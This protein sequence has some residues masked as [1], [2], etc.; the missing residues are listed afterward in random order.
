M[1]RCLF[2]LLCALWLLGTL[3]LPA[4]AREIPEGSRTDCAVE[5]RVEYRGVPLSG[6]TLTAV[7][8]G[9]I[10]QED[11]NFSFRRCFDGLPLEDIQ[12]PAAAAQLEEFL[13]TGKYPFERQTVPIQK[14]IAAFQDLPTG[15]YLI[16]Q[17]ASTEGYLPL[18]P[19][20]VSLPYLE[21]GSY[22]YHLTADAKTA[23]D[24][25]PE[26]TAPPPEKP[27]GD[28][29]QTGQQNLPVPILSAL[30]LALLILGNKL[31]KRSS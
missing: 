4:A 3:P 10:W 9:E 13:R 12:S 8:V 29:P 1:K 21:N 19:F 18:N 7:R 28:L 24:P 5:V 22:R 6:G 17:E 31:R 20:L 23:P 15:L 30:G 25:V 11:G 16:L 2:S 26:P 27:T 14:G